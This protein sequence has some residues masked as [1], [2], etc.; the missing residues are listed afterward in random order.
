MRRPTG[1]DWS[2]P[3]YLGAPSGPG[4]SGVWDDAGELHVAYMDRGDYALYYRKGAA[5]TPERITGGVR[6]DGTQWLKA[7]IG[8]DV[9]LRV[10]A[11]GQP[12]VVY[13]D[14]TF[15]TFYAARRDA[16]GQWTTRVL[17]QKSGGV[18][19]HGFYGTLL[20]QPGATVAAEYVI[21]NGDGSAEGEA[22]LHAL[23]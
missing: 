14:A 3:E 19:A 22:V 20:R 1:G 11:D 6:D 9:T 10:R 13:H 23:D 17:G 7:D 5:G 12:E 8:E 4:V 2:A 18:E 21:K 15:H 16:S